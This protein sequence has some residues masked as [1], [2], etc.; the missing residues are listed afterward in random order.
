MTSEE[1]DS[2]LEQAKPNMIKAVTDE[3]VKSVGYDVRAKASALINAHVEAWVKENVLPEITTQ[4]VESKESLVSLGVKLGPAIVDTV[5]HS[6]TTEVSER[7]TKSWERK[8][9]FEA[10]VG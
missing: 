9:I 1:I 5:V 10:L 7:L 8:K 4:L 2:L 6:L 3:L